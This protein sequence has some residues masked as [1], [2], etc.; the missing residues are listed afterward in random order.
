MLRRKRFQQ[1]ARI[2]VVGVGNGGMTAVNAM[3]EA[4]INSVD[5]VV[6]DSCRRDL[7][8]SRASL[9]VYTGNDFGARE[10]ESRRHQL[11]SAL[12]G[13]DM[14]FLVG[15]LGGVTS[16]QLAPLVIS[17]AREVGALTTAIVTTPFAFEGAARA[18]KAQETVAYLRNVVNTL[19]VVPNDRL[20]EMA[21][22]ALP[23]HKTYDLALEIWRQSV[24][25]VSDLVNAP[26]L[27]NVDFADV[28]TIMKTGGPSIIAMGRARGP[29]RAQKAAEQAINAPYLDV[30]IDGARGV[31]FN[32]CGG[33]DM[34]LHEVRQAASVIRQRADPD[35]N[36]IFGATVDDALNG[37]ICMTLIAT[38]CG[39]AAPAFSIAPEALF[40][41]TSLPESGGARAILHRMM[42]QT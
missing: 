9:T 10:A 29:F 2:R 8:K 20:L 13:S 28:R 18:K 38:G 19:I 31:L 4:G 26:G 12:R 23:F 16:G 24:Q 21:G 35:V 41:E 37:E 39:I 33:Q 30:T 17:V 27:V 34:T 1:L 42:T 5:F 32:I 15:G 14:V 22:G 3:I 6:A 40:S 36:L 7:R 25:G 11:R